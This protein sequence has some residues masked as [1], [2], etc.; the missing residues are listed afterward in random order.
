MTSTEA[1]IALTLQTSKTLDACLEAHCDVADVEI[2]L[3]NLIAYYNEQYNERYAGELTE[4]D[5]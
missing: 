5:D 2:E 1:L 4:D 3:V